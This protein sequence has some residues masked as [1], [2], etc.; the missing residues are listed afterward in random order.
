MITKNGLVSGGDPH[1]SY[2][3]GV[4]EVTLPKREDAKQKQ[5]KVEI[6]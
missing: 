4:L 2:K 3:D 1:A 6:K 5:V